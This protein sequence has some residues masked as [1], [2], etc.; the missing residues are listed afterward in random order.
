MSSTNALIIVAFSALM[1]AISFLIGIWSKKKATTAQAYFG[2]TAMFGPVAVGLS[3]MAGIASAFAMVGVPGIIYG[4]GN[5]MTF[6]MLSGA[7]FAM[8]Y[9]ILGK[10]MRAMAEI[11]PISSLGDICDIRFNNNRIIK[12]LMSIVICLGC[13]GYL[14]AQISAGSALI[15][16]LVDIPPIVAGIII[17]G[18]LTV[19]TALSGEVGGLL[20]QAFQ[21]FIMVIASLVLIIAFFSITGGFG[22]V[23][24]A[25]GSVAEVTGATNGITKKLGPDLLN[26]WGSFPG[27]ISLTWMLI[28]ILGCVGQPQCLTRMYA[29]KSPRDLPKAGLVTAVTHTIVGFLAVASAYGALYLV[30]TG[31]IEPLAS[32]DQAV[33]AF[34]NHLGLWAQVLVYAAILAAAL[35]SASMFLTSSST[36]LSKDLPSAL[37]IKIAPEKQISVSRVF[38]FILG[39]VAI[40]V[41]IYSSEMVALLGTFGWGT[42]VSATFPVFVVG[43][44]WDRCTEAGALVGIAYSFVFNILPLVTGFAYPSALPGYFLTSAIAV[45]LTVVVSLLTPKPKFNEAMQAVMD[46]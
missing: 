41:S 6:W 38:M 28:P 16:N 8:A 40:V 27:G 19:Y 10:K 42:L 45:A 3:S 43:L 22:N 12:A 9:I 23:L 15:A 5:A 17:F 14:A 25:V 31:Q 30:A 37:G 24:E 32:N 11:A 36:L 21:G 46:L 26:A 4:T 1:I 7:A 29:V 20:S 33:Y 34:A 13:V 44:L 18:L 2:G 39:A 35:S